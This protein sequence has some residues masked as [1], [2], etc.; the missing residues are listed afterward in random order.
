MDKL[1]SKGQN[2]TGNQEISAEPIGA[3]TIIYIS[4]GVK[5][6]VAQSCPTLGD[7]IHCILLGSF[8]HGIFPGKNTGVGSHTLLQGI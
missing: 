4:L 8:V 2:Q 3:N 6:L 5:V 7:P 1:K